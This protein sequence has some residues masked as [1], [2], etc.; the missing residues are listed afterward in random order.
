MYKT[1]KISKGLNIDLK[2][3]A[4]RLLQKVARSKIYALNRPTF[5]A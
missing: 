5:M 1:V 4:D 3:E 2:G